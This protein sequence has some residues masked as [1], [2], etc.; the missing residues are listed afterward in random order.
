MN[1]SDCAAAAWITG[2]VIATGVLQWATDGQHSVSDGL[3][4]HPTATTLLAV[5]FAAHLLRRP[6]WFRRCDPFHAIGV[7]IHRRTP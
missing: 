3:R 6:A 2:G 1:P 5:A 7:T 4:R